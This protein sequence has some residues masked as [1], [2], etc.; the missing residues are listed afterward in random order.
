MSVTYMYTMCPF[1]N[2]DISFTAGK[3]FKRRK[4]LR[5]D[6]R[7]VPSGKNIFFELDREFWANSAT[8]ARARGRSRARQT[9]E[10]DSYATVS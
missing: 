3:N 10:K 7:T 8:H 4:A 9:S 2:D 5:L 1:N 6:A